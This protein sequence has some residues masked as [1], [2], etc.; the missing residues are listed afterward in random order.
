MIFSWLFK[1]VICD[2]LRDVLIENGWSDAQNRSYFEGDIIRFYCNYGY[3]SIGKTWRTCYKNE[4]E[5][6]TWSDSTPTCEG[7]TN[8]RHFYY[9]QGLGSVHF[10]KGERDCYSGVPGGKGET[11]APDTTYFRGAW[12]W[13]RHDIKT[14][15][16]IMNVYRRKII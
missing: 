12:R 14:I 6:T 15:D 1:V 4:S 16:Q 7:K 2:P 8:Q 13:I 11:R 9:N 3:R 5:I 10:L